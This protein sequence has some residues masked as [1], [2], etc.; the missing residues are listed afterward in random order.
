MGEKYKVE[1]I[2]TFKN[3]TPSGLK[4][5]NLI[6]F[7]YKSPEGVHD[8]TPLVYISTKSFDRCFG[9]NVHYDSK[10]Y[11]N[12]L[13]NINWKVNPILE[14]EWY[15]AYPERQKQLKEKKL[16]FD[17]S[18]IEKEDLKKYEKKIQRKDL[19]IFDLTKINK[20]TLRTYLFKRMNG[21]SKLV[22]KIV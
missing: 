19:E 3:I 4:S 22:F 5:G 15:K 14:K 16:K 12:I 7:N 21:V 17:K 8:R 13:N 1:K 20:D 10:E 18:L 6:F 11:Q 9:F 2:F